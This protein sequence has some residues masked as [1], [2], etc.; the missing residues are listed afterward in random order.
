MMLKILYRLIQYIS[1]NNLK[2]KLYVNLLKQKL[3]LGESSVLY[4][5]T[6]IENFQNKI[7]QIK[8]GAFTHVRGELL[9]FPHGG[10]ILIGNH[11]YIGEGSR[12]WSAANIQIGN[13]VLIAHNVNIHDNISH[14]IDAVTRH[15]HYKHI[16]T[17]GHPHEIDLNEKPIIIKDNAW[18]GFN[19]TIL[20]GTT[21]GERAV[22]GAGAMITKDIPNDAIAVGNPAQI[23][24]YVN[25]IKLNETKDKEHNS[26]D[27]K[28]GL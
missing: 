2:D 11:C 12:I 5:T 13:N 15:N 19:A 26:P 7:D 4:P 28:I 25:N 1:L 17:K 16:I 23:I 20:K 6:K 27:Q 24:G 22:I 14:P 18:I 8:I 9:I 3:I 21:I 10:S